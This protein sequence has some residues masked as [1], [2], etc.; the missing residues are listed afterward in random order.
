[1]LGSERFQRQIAEM[2]DRRVT[3]VRPGPKLKRRQE[4]VAE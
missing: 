3:R 4:E 2:L 1:V